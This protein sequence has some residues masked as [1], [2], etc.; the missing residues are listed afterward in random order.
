[1]TLV[2]CTKSDV[3][4]E[5]GTD[6]IVGTWFLVEVNGTDI[7]SLDCINN[8]FIESD[9]VT[10][11]FFIQNEDDNGECETLANS[12]GEFTFEN[13]VYSIDGESF[14]FDISGN[15]LSWDID[16]ETNFEFRK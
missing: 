13:N 9:A 3:N 14:D 5:S 15:T 1:M 7:T 12:T 16:S 8:S 6:A 2:S 4:D 11:T 10:I